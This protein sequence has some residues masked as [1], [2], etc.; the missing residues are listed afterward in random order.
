MQLYPLVRIKRLDLSFTA[1]LLPLDILALFCAGLSSY[2]LRYS[3]FVTEVLPILQNVPFSQYMSSVA[4]FVAAW[5]VLFALTGLYSTTRRRAW[6]ELGRI[7]IACAAGTMLVIATV[8]F[9]REIAASRFIVLAV[10]GFSIVYVWLE[11]LFLRVVR[12]ALLRARVGHRL[13]AVIGGSATANE[14][15]A[16]YNKNPIFGVTVVKHFSSWNAETRKAIEKIK[17]TTG[18]DGVL[19]AD[20]DMD[21]EKS[22]DLIAFSEEHNLAFTYLADL[23]AASFTN[24]AVTTETGVPII[25]VKRTP[26]E[27]WGRIGKRAFDIIFSFLLLLIT[28]PILLLAALALIIEDGMPVIF[29]NERVG[30]RGSLFKTY[31]LRSM[32]R[33]FSIGPQFKHRNDDNLA[34]EQ[35]LIKERSIK[36]GPLYKIANDPRVTPVG[37]FIRRWSID[38]LPQFW[39]V[40]VGDMSLVGPR[41]HQPR[42]VDKYEPSQ[43]RVL[44]IRPGITGM[45]QISGRS[46]LVFED[47]ARIDI[48]Y[49]ENWSLGLDLYILLKTPFVVLQRKG[50]Y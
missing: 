45:A 27:G 18:L 44:A 28:S 9:R 23:F 36:Q 14:V 43:R 41:P 25:E 39:N 40:L 3:R 26:L 6:G 29:Q 10:F 49:I 46:D 38:E 13:F 19:L 21:K 7:I 24:I 34:Y 2:L 42:E 50:A 1:L 33:K 48:W 37:E 30:E 12:H 11:R 16:T 17:N 47:E 22:L 20:P 8:F 4:I 32:W 31:K 5:I 35:T 15:A